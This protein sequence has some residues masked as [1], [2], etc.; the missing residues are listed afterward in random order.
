MRKSHPPIK[1]ALLLTLALALSSCSMIPGYSEPSDQKIISAIG[2]DADRE[3]ITVIL[4]SVATEKSEAEVMVGKGAT[5]ETALASLLA[6][7]KSEPEVSHC[8]LAVLGEGIDDAWL[9]KILDYF[10][11]NDNLTAAAYFVSAS[12][13]EK[14]L[15][16]EGVSGYDLAKA[17]GENGENPGMDA[18]S[19]YYRI[20]AAR[21]EKDKLFAL[22]HFYSDGEK[23]E[24]YGMT[25]YQND[26]QTVTLTRAESGYYMMLRGLFKG[27]LI[28]GDAAGL[29]GSIGIAHCKTEYAFTGDELKIIFRI[30]PD[31]DLGGDEYAVELCAHTEKKLAELYGELSGRYGDVFNLS[32]IAE[33][34]GADFD[35]T[36]RVTFE[37]VT[38]EGR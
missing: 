29:S 38:R 19:Q 25:V 15:S 36:T 32:K 11:R 24:L 16:V 23:A 33:W 18:E 34:E 17:I 10:S 37:C 22:P 13:A 27:S 31:Q 30:T 3:G 6:D 5:I 21:L 35:E 28:S 20:A 1:V 9:S 26:R 8:A 7:Q 4:K 2:F 14:L 12:N